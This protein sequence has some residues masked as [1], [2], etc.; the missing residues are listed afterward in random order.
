M[1]TTEKEAIEVVKTLKKYCKKNGCD[2]CILKRDG[3]CVAK[4]PCTAFW[5]IKHEKME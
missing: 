1:S 4:W 5:R 3:V 2:T